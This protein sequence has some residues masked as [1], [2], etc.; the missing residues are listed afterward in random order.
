MTVGKIL[1]HVKAFADIHK[2]R[3]QIDSRFD[4]FNQN[5]VIGQHDTKQSKDR[6]AVM[7]WKQRGTR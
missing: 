5:G 2:Y 1:H 6:A 7:S 4:A 3:M